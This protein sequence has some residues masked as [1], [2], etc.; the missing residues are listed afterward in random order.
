MKN[1]KVGIV[2]TGNIGSVVVKILHGFGCSLMGYDIKKNEF[3]ER[4][5]DL[6]YVTLEKIYQESDII[7]IHV[8]LNSNTKYLVNENILN[9]LKNNVMIINTSRGAIV[10]TK[11]LIKYLTNGKIGFY[12]A[13]VYEDEKNIFFKDLSTQKLKDNIF[14]KLLSFKNVTITPHQAFATEEALINIATTNI[15]N[16]HCWQNNYTCENEI[17]KNNQHNII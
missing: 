12:G 11:D 8:P 3:L 9:K 2:G 6:K 15:K 13:D 17:K 4:E 14:M 16:L 10:N 5:Y 1:K 7:S